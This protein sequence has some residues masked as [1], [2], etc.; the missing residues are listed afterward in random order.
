M[1]PW[2]QVQWAISIFR[3]LIPHPA[4]LGISLIYMFIKIQEIETISEVLGVNGWLHR[5]VCLCLPIGNGVVALA[6]T[7]QVL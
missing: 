1:A 4:G 7:P 3:G 6:N 2:C 5:T